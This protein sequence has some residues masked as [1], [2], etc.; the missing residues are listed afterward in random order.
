[1]LSDEGGAI[2][3]R[4]KDGGPKIK[5]TNFPSV[6]NQPG[7][8]LRT[9]KDRDEILRLAGLEDGVQERSW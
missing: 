3:M 9:V 6:R 4:V 1:M 7:A 5:L 8:P 2:A